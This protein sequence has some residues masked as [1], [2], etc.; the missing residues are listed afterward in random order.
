MRGLDHWCGRCCWRRC[1]WRGAT[2]ALHEAGLLALRERY[3]LGGLAWRMIGR[4]ALFS[5]TPGRV[6][7]W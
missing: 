7:L 1:S 6:R 4:R 2:M 3:F 5:A